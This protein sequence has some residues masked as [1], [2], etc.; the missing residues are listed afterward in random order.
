MAALWPGAGTGPG[1]DVLLRAHRML[2]DGV[3]RAAVFGRSLAHGGVE[4]RRWYTAGRRPL[5]VAV[6]GFV[7]VANAAGGIASS[8]VRLHADVGAGLRIS[9][10]GTGVL[11]L[12]LARGLRDGNTVLSIGWI[13]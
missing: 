9:L 8:D 13:R 2:D 1:R 12:D 4:A 10:P 11:R 7:D 5:R 3:I 6:A